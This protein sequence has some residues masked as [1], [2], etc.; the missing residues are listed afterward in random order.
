MEQTSTYLE[1]AKLAQTS[2]EDR[3]RY[4]WRISFSLWIA[5][6]SVGYWFSQ[7]SAANSLSGF[8]VVL[9]CAAPFFHYWS[10]HNIAR[11]HSIDKTQ[12]HYWLDRCDTSGPPPKKSLTDLI[13]D[14]E[15]A[16]IESGQNAWIWMQVAFTILL[17]VAVLSL[18]LSR[19]PSPVQL[20]L[21]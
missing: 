17:E 9:S 12:R 4:E 19:E 18:L 13:H 10:H 16:P 3:R 11:A 21:M 14:A 20:P 15:S 1:L 6:G 2:F 8:W 5:I 7:A